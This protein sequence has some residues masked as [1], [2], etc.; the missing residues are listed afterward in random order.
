[1]SL[2][3]KAAS[4]WTV[5]NTF[6]TWIGGWHE[7]LHSTS[8]PSRISLDIHI[9][10]QLLY[11]ID[12]YCNTLSYAR[13]L[14]IVNIKT[15]YMILKIWHKLSSWS[16][17]IHFS[18]NAIRQSHWTMKLSTRTDSHQ[19]NEQKYQALKLF[20]VLF[21]TLIKIHKMKYFGH[22]ESFEPVEW[23]WNESSFSDWCVFHFVHLNEWLWQ[24]NKINNFLY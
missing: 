4:V 18:A 17:C 1:M 7:T 19:Y 23:K 2:A 15:N 11:H 21:L 5:H 13:T 6:S 22:S 14:V 24:R 8:Y 12:V 10:F 3:H 16:N 20:S 9:H